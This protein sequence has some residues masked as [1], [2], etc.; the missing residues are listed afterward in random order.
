MSTQDDLAPNACEGCARP[1]VRT[2]A[3]TDDGAWLCIHCYGDARERAATER[4]ADWIEA[5]GKRRFVNSSMYCSW[6]IAAHAIRSGEHTGTEGE[7][8]PESNT[9]AVMPATPEPTDG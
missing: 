7:L 5:E 9:N 4:I 1:N 3:R 2:M 6:G 8:P